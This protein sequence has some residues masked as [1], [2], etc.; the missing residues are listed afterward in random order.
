MY[1]MLNNETV[2][3]AQVLSLLE[4]KQYLHACTSLIILEYKF[5]PL[6][7]TLLICGKNRTFLLGDIL[8]LLQHGDTVGVRKDRKS[9]RL[10]SSHVSIS[11]A[12]F[13]LK[14]KRRQ[15]R[16]SVERTVASA[17]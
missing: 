10:N 12:V 11:Y 15:V 16:T 8:Y 1:A 3:R 5:L 17:T 7:I 2:D 14:K 13:C 9:T 4:N 6:L